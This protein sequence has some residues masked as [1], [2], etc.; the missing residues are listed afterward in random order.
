[1][2]TDMPKNIEKLSSEKAE[3]LM[4]EHQM[5]DFLR[6]TRIFARMKP[7]QKVDVV[8]LH[9]KKG[10][11][12]MVGDGAN[13]AAALQKAHTG[14]AI[15]ASGCGSS[16]RD[17]AAIV[18]HFATPA[19]SLFKFADLM[20]HGRGALA[21]IM[22]AYKYLIAYGQSCSMLNLIHLYMG[23]S[24]SE[25]YWL[26]MDVLLNISLSAC[27]ME[28]KPSKK[29]MP[30]RP[31]A[32][33]LGPETLWS[34]ILHCGSN[35]L[36]Y[37]IYIVIMYQQG[38]FRC[39][40]FDASNM[41]VGDWWLKGDNYETST[42]GLMNLFMCFNAAFVF[43][44]GFDYRQSFFKN[45]I[46]PVVWVIW[47]VFFYCLLMTDAN[48]LVCAYRLNCGDQ[49]LLSLWAENDWLSY[50]GQTAMIPPGCPCDEQIVDDPRCEA[51]Y[52]DCQMDQF[53]Q[54]YHHDIIP[55][56]F[57]WTTFGI[58]WANFTWVLLCEGLLVVGP[59]RKYLRKKKD[60]HSK[61]IVGITAMGAHND[62]TMTSDKG[63]STASSNSS[64]GPSESASEDV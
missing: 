56:D 7:Q 12:A 42:L 58:L 21:T 53:N 6:Y 28:T 32:R 39:R 15:S 45:W 43:N 22:H 34:M 25:L 37:I 19:D 8:S 38:W 2:L 29:L 10:V 52:I 50:K 27:I 33:L 64:E 9:M 54:F 60:S 44:F 26:H 61:P 5:E 62:E 36:F 63:V 47:T 46:I 16:G 14:M 20:R 1:M 49:S 30:N 17:V 51:E 55:T 3:A 31:T 40:E 48:P 23:M 11:T 41:A 35:L 4:P 18:A 24:R 13:D 57:R 59:F